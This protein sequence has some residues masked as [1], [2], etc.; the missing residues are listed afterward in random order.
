L[1]SKK[2]TDF[3]GVLHVIPLNFSRQICDHLTAQIKVLL[4]RRSGEQCSRDQE[5]TRD[6]SKLDAA[7]DGGIVHGLQKLLVNV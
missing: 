3:N 4:T 2:A 7:A 5:K 1:K 6:V